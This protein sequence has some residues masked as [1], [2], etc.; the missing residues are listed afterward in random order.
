MIEGERRNGYFDRKK[1]LIQT[2]NEMSQLRVEDIAE[3][4]EPFLPRKRPSRRELERYHIND[5]WFANPKHVN[6]GH[7]DKGHL[8]RVHILGS[9]TL[10]LS[11]EREGISVESIPVSLSA[12]THDLLRDADFGVFEG[13]RAH[14]HRAA[15]WIRENWRLLDPNLSPETVEKIAFLN[16]EHSEKWPTAGPLENELTVVM[17]ADRLDLTRG[18]AVRSPLIPPIAKSFSRAVFTLRAARWMNYD[19]AE[20][21]VPVAY[22]LVRE[23]RR[24]F[25]AYQRDPDKESLDAAQRLGII[26]D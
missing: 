14:A 20:D 16:H 12:L 24:D 26:I 22:A 13:Q 9:A 1:V 18:P 25:A 3:K 21:L 23:S 19:W 2:T 17:I 11:E 4:I 7:H 6:T 10:N 15:D 8:R 5:E